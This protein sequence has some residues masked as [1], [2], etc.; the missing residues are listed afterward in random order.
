MGCRSLDEWRRARTEHVAAAED[1]RQAAAENQRREVD[2]A[3]SRARR[4][5]AAMQEAKRKE[6]EET[7]AGHARAPESVQEARLRR[8]LKTMEDRLAALLE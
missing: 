7:G 4:K 1:W 8:E 3:A 2:L 5:L 6:E